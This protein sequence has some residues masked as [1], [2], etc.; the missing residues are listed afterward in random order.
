MM[1]CATVPEDPAVIVD[2]GDM[3]QSPKI[4]EYLQHSPGC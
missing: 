1:I 4:G 2:L 3:E